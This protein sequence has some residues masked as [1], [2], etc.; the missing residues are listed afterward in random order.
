MVFSSGEKIEGR[1]SRKEMLRLIAYMGPAL[2]VSVAY[3]DPGNFASDI[4][5]G[6]TTGYVLLW[7]VWL[8]GL[9]GML[10]Q[11]LS[12]KL[13]LATGKSLPELV[14]ATLRKRKYIIPYWLSAEAASAAVDLAEFL[15]TVLA[16]NLLFGIP[17]LEATYIAVFDVFLMIY[18]SKKGF[19]KLEKAFFLFVG[20]IGLSYVYELF[21]VKPDI[22]STVYYSVIPEIHQAYVVLIMS[23]IGA[24]VMPH[25]L[26]YHSDLVRQKVKGADPATKRA[27]LGYHRNDTILF[28]G[29]ASFVNAAMLIMAAGGFHARGLNDVQTINDAYYT[30]LPLFGKLAGYMFVAALLSSGISAST[31]G[32]LAGQSVMEGMLGRNVNPWK[33]RLVTRFINV[34]P[35]TIAIMIGL[36]PFYILF[37]SQVVLSIMIPLPMIP[38][39]VYTSQ[40]SR[41]GEFVNRKYTVALAVLSA[42]T[43]IVFN[44]YYLATL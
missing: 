15:G 40:R 12:G 43:I 9:M 37:Y 30:L 10:L 1:Y 27:T 22:S 20:M 36:N 24:T 32:T 14:S 4:E 42:T 44:V 34:I 5:T 31:L 6:A 33:R 38:L 41:M 29:A 13:G 11:Y 21:L 25:V 19:R 2:L 7:V 3:I 17:Y 16:L 28:L 35:T 26:F 39:I 8:A 23:I 18:L